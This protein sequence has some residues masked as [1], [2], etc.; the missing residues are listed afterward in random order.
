MRKKKALKMMVLLCLMFAVLGV[1]VLAWSGDEPAP[2]PNGNYPFL[3]TANAQKKTSDSEEK[4][5]DGDMYAYITPRQKLKLSNVT[6]YSNAYE[7]GATSYFKVRTNHVSTP[8]AT[9]L[10]TT[11][12][13]GKKTVRYLSTALANQ[14]EYVLRGEIDGFNFSSNPSARL[15]VSW[16]P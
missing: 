4:P 2:S 12:V 7:K 5:G 15:C 9:G 16:C 11:K 6:Y 14:G 8:E 10:L 3:F 1:P 13:Y